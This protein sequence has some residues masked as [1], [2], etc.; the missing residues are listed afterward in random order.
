MQHYAH[1][2]EGAKS[3]DWQPLEQ[4]LDN[5]AKLAAEFAKPFGGEEWAHLAGLWYDLGKYS[6]D[7]QKMLLEAN[8]IKWRVV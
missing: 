3:K 1:S 2:K 8:G 6:P 7:F 4:H 5:V